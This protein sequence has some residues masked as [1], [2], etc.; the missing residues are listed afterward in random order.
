[1]IARI[2][3]LVARTPSVKVPFDPNR[4]VRETLAFMKG[5]MARLHVVLHT[6]LT[7]SLPEVLGDPVQIQQVL[8]NIVMNALDA[9]GGV[10]DRRRELEVRSMRGGASTVLLAVLDSGV[11]IAPALRDRIFEPFYTTKSHGLGMGLAISRSIVEEHGGQLWVVPHDGP[12]TTVQ[13]T[14][15][16]AGEE[17]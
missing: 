5:E 2:R 8:L 14:I 4:L 10:E 17:S 3:S 11:G 12:G 16:V 13:F 6:Q 1:V 9:I 7:P 15:P